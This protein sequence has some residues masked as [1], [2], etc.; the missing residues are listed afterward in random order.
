MVAPTL[1]ALAALSCVEG[2]FGPG[3]QPAGTL[4]VGI[5]LPPE[6]PAVWLPAGDTLRIAL[7]R[8]GRVEPIA[9]TRVAV[10]GSPPE[11]LTIPFS[12]SLESFVVS[13]ELVYSGSVYF[14]GFEAVR[15]RAGADTT[16]T[17]A[18]AYVGPGARAA[19]YALGL[20][21]P[22]I[23]RGDTTS[24][25]P[26][27]LD[28]L[29]QQIQNVP[30]RYVS[31]RPTVVDVAPTGLLTAQP[32]PPDTARIAG[33]LPMGLGDSLL[34][35]VLSRAAS[36]ATVGGDNQA[37]QRLHRLAMPIT[38]Q[39]LGDD[40]LP[41][42]GEPVAFAADSASGSFAPSVAQSDSIGRA[43][44]FWT[45]GPRLGQQGATVSVQGV[46]PVRVAATAGALP[47]DSVLVV[48]AT[49]TLTGVGA[50]RILTAAVFDSIGEPLSGMTV[51]WASSNTSVVSVTQAGA[52]EAV[53]V[54]TATISASVGA[55]MGTAQ[56]TV[57]P[58]GPW[59]APEEIVFISTRDGNREVYA[60]EA[61][62]SGARRITSTP[63]EEYQ[64]AWAP[65][66]SAVVFERDVAGSRQVFRIGADGSAE[67]QLTSVGENTGPRFSLDGTTIGFT[68]DRAGTKEVWAMDAGGGSQRRLIDPG[69]QSDV[70]ADWAPDGS[71]L[72]FIRRP[73]VGSGDSE[74]WIADAD[75][76]SLRKVFGDDDGSYPDLVAAR[77]SP[78]GGEIVYTRVGSSG[79]TELGSRTLEDRVGPLGSVANVSIPFDGNAAFAGAGNVLAFESESAGGVRGVYWRTSAGSTSRLSPD[80]TEEFEPDH[81]PPAS[82]IYV[83][84]IDV[85]PSPV[86]LTSDQQRRAFAASARDVNGTPVSVPLR[87]IRRMDGR[88]ASLADSV[89]VAVAPGTTA[90]V[91]TYGGWRTD[92][93]SVSIA[94]ATG[95]SNRRLVFGANYQLFSMRGDGIDVV[96]LTNLSNTQ[97]D[98]TYSPD[99]SRIAW[100]SY[101]DG[102][103]EI[104]VMNADG[105]GQQ[106]LTDNTALDAYPSWSPDGQRLVF[107]SDRAGGRWALWTMAANG[108]SPQQLTFPTTVDHVDPSWSPDG[109][110]IAF[111][112]FPVTGSNMFAVR[113]QGGAPWSL[114]LGGRYPAWTPAGDTLLFV[115][116]SPARIRRRALAGGAVTDLTTGCGLE[117]C[118]LAGDH[119]PSISSD[120]LVLFW[121]TRNSSQYGQLMVMSADGSSQSGLV[122][123]G[124]QEPNG[125]LFS[126]SGEW[127]P[128]APAPYVASVVI[129]G[130]V[131]NP[132]PLPGTRQLTPSAL[133]QNGQPIVPA[134]GFQ[135]TALDPTRATV[136]STGLVTAVAPGTSRVVLRSGIA[137]PDTVTLTVAAPVI[138]VTRTWV[139]GAAGTPTD[140]FT[141]SNWSPAGVPNAVDT[142][143]IVSS[144]NPTLLTGDAAVARLVLAGGSLTLNG[145]RLSVSGDFQTGD[146]SSPSGVLTM[147]NVADT[148]AV[149]GDATFAGSP[150]PGRL[151]A[152]V[153]LVAGGFSQVYVGGNWEAF[154]ASGT[155]RTVLNGSAAQTVSFANPAATGQ[156]SFFQDLEVANPVGVTFATSAVANGKLRVSAASALSGAGTV[157]VRDSIV[158]V[159]GS[160]ISTA[161]VG[162]GGGM[163]VSGTFAPTRTEFF[164]SGAVIQPGLGYRDVLVTGQVSLGGTTTFDGNLV[165]HRLVNQP[166]GDLT[167]AGRKLTVTGNLSTGSGSDATGVL[168]MQNAADTLAVGGDATFAGSPLPGRLTAGVLLV[169]GGFSQVYVGGNWEA[170]QASGTHRTVL[171]GSAA[172]TVS[173]ANPAAT[174]QASFFQD[175]E[176]ANP[177]GVTFATSAVANGKLR[178]SAA[179]PVAGAGT[180]SVGDS[181][182][183]VA[184]SSVA[185]AGMRL[186]GGMAVAGTYSPTLTE[187]FGNGTEVQPGLGY[188]SVLVTGQVSLGG[189]TTFDGDLT[190]GRIVNQA[191]GNLTIAGRRLT[192]TGNLRTGQGGD[193]TGVLTMQNAAD[194]LAVGGDATFA[195]SPLPGRLT[196]GV[197][198]VAGGFSQVYVGGNWE[199]FQASGTHRTV[200]NGSAPQTISFT[201]PAFSGQASFFQ[202]LE[203]ASAG[204]VTLASTV[205]AN[206]QLRARSGGMRTVTGGGNSL[207][208]RGVD[209][210]SLVM[211]GATLTTRGGTLARFD[212]VTFQNMSTAA[213]QLAVA[214]SGLGSPYTFT[215]LRFLTVPT[216]G[217]YV[218]A[219]DSAQADGSV[220]TIRLASSEPADGSA[221]TTTTAAVVTWLGAEPPPFAGVSAGNAFGCGLAQSGKPFCWGQNFD[222]TVGDGTTM[223]RNRPTAVS[224][225]LTFTGVSAGLAH[226]CGLTAAGAAYC[227]GSNGYGQLGNNSTTN[228]LVPVAVVT[229]LAFSQISAGEQHT[230]ARTAAGVVYCWG[231]NGNGQLGDGTTT[232][233]LTPT[234]V[235]GS[236]V[237]ASVSAGGLHTCARTA[238]GVA[239]CWG[240]NSF[241]QLG[242][243]SGLQQ[244][245][246]VA[247]SGG[248]AFSSVSAGASHTCAVRTTTGAADCWGWNG[249]GQLGSGN[250]TAS[251]VPVAVAGGLSFGSISAAAGEFTCALTTGGAAYC[252]G[253]NDVGQLGSG[254]N[255][256]RTTPGAVSGGLT[257]TSIDAGFSHV[258]AVAQGGA[259]YTWGSNG[260]GQLGDGTTTGSSV[261]VAVLPPN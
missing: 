112:A 228:S 254:N 143:R 36:I 258:S 78:L 130:D 120:G 153:L 26:T 261:P 48:P 186:G 207:L 35:T 59:Y 255:T 49:V 38:I 115:G 34:V 50:S 222:G 32:V 121:S 164:G 149:G 136:D 150:L 57:V 213:T 89:L 1:V 148:L 117:V 10:G 8:A 243:G 236:L 241:G 81:V 113:P 249:S 98:P 52:V 6:T 43:S 76:G 108:S 194:T 63:E 218:A 75:G 114:G 73:S 167:L 54:G 161:G 252:W 122:P 137:P 19:S 109:S 220:L 101:Q 223:Q 145:N 248:L 157:S 88:T 39:V 127:Q 103:A 3:N 131:T 176:V 14:L 209:V 77:W 155:H 44:S 13:A 21:A 214:H 110:I 192:V 128:L 234:A 84:D 144:A 92:S 107:T 134:G 142:V 53:A 185:P 201:N 160:S 226:A 260:S 47:P 46:A 245:S 41:V 162:L 64:P 244:V 2:P 15:L 23:R 132:V 256:P 147:Q 96:Q 83:D 221:R 171:N 100:T 82:R 173:F 212:N 126:S 97:N 18:T 253:L 232:D 138:P 70:F 170:F 197:L 181:L 11:S 179:A 40:G 74:A 140:W 225:G 71:G 94:P 180:V 65:D 251:L 106:R 247:V 28:S 67:T 210:D 246:P 230:C 29:G 104:F 125:F 191:S 188:Q 31:R 80:G 211:D 51:A 196:A 99:G 199:A 20:Q 68:S 169:A 111:A 163:A 168:T 158:T 17:I 165:I 141:A 159:A 27:V 193:A 22:M 177:V 123:V 30:A 69:G 189:T 79:N 216:T 205:F 239:Y 66:R 93:A 12:H 227:W 151:T 58:G 250:T 204:G 190:I 198:L 133:N 55:V 219:V 45:L 91:A 62:G 33:Y 200:L 4:S 233:R 208:V 25:L 237:L 139:G 90:L 116:G 85:Q 166:A 206:G 195:G 124:S 235:S 217:Y 16:L 95:P 184:G 72:V 105:S 187:L 152:G 174:G 215:G 242:D 60:M 257:L 129:G 203:I 156:A 119:E 183:T 42:V 9:E 175:L 37:A 135:W 231:G 61:D 259:G 154:Q 146:G 24:L 7:R 224:G 229:G 87:W 102:D 118:A 56:V 238:A 5:T 86:D 240:S 178:V 172:Q 182:V 202:N